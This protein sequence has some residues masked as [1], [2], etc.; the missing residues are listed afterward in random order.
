VTVPNDE[1]IARTAIRAARH[2]RPVAT[3]VTRRRTGALP[4]SAR[5]AATTATT[6]MPADREATRRA[7]PVPRVPDATA[8]RHDH[9]DPTGVTTATRAGELTVR[10]D[11]GLAR[12]DRAPRAGMTATATRVHHGPARS[13]RTDEHLAPSVA[14]TVNRAIAVPVS[15]P[16]EHGPTLETVR[17]TCDPIVHRVADPIDDPAN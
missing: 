5:L 2:A 14:T 11:Q 8:V 16:G 13:L 4:V 3:D 7:A 9:R 12:K 6:L 1:S 10:R 15:R 17:V